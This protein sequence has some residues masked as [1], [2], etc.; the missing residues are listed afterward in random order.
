[1]NSFSKRRGLARKVADHVRSPVPG[2]VFFS[3]V[4]FGMPLIFA[5]VNDRGGGGAVLDFIALAMAL[6]LVAEVLFRFAYRLYFGAAYQCFPRL[7]FS[8]IYVEPHPYIPFVCK[9]NFKYEVGGSATYPLH[10]GRFEFGQYTSNNIGFLNGPNGDRKTVIPKPSGLFR[11]NC[12]GASTTGNYIV[13]DGV[14]FSYPMELEKILQSALAGPVEVNNCGQGGYNSAD[15]LVRFSLQVLDTQP[16]VLVIYHAYN[17]IRD[18]LTPNFQPDY[19]HSRR[20]IGE[21]YWKF[22]LAS[23]IPYI[24]IKF[25]NYLTNNWLPGNI[26]NSLIDQITKG[27]VDASI[28]PTLGLQTFRRNLQSIINLAHCNGI[29]V[30]LSTFCHYI[31][32][33]IKSDPL[34]RLYGRIVEMENNVI[35]E[36][37]K[38]NNLDFIDNAVGIPKD[39]RYFLDSIHFTPEGMQLLARNIADALLESTKKRKTI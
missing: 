23:K 22:A 36:L 5:I 39:A 1:M 10:Q 28:N 8:R 34:H 35:R 37:A 17:D 19:S 26:R 15:L 3:M 12:I 27:V 20:N 4:F 24:P 6:L 33:G 18:Y 11:V 13:A 14:S 25:L 38:S 29:R 2:V 31:H 30:I 21:S 7:E 32:D 16:D 9:K